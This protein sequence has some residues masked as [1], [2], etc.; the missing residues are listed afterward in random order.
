[1]V[2]CIIFTDPLDDGEITEENGYE[3]YPSMNVKAI[4]SS[5][6]ADD[7]QMVLLATHPPYNEGV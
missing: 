2:G 4:F 5:S 7:I 3:A 6:E 1:M